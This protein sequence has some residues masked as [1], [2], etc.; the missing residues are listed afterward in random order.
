MS[1][2]LQSRDM[3]DG[4]IDVQLLGGEGREEREIINLVFVRCTLIVIPVK[5][6][7]R[8]TEEAGQ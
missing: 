8:D 2:T 4:F 1:K 3:L 7:W 6:D 5:V